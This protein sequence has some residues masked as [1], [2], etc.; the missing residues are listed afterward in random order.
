ML[1][2]LANAP[3]IFQLYIKKSLEEKPDVFCIV[4]LDDIFSYTSKK[5]S[6]YE[7][8]VR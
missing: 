1:F 5:S 8:A 4:Y 6:K 2:G 3:A 7:K